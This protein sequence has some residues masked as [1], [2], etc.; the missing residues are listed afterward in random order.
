[1]TKKE[2]IEIIKS[3]KKTY[4]YFYS[5]FC[6]AC[7]QTEPLLESVGTPVKKI[8]GF[9]DEKLLDAFDIEFYPTIVEI[10]GNK[11]RTFSGKVAIDNLLS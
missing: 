11:K 1:M 10:N 9:E 8:I 5:P 4:L 6:G 2:L 7:E 3:G